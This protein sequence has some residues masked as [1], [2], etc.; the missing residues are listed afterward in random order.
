M[1]PLST[2]PNWKL[3]GNRPRTA[4]VHAYEASRTTVISSRWRDCF[5]LV[6]SSNDGLAA[7]SCRR[8]SVHPPRLLPGPALKGK[9][10]GL[11]AGLRMSKAEAEPW[12]HAVSGTVPSASGGIGLNPR[13]YHRRPQ[14]LQGLDM[15]T[16]SGSQM[17]CVLGSLGPV[18]GF[19]SVS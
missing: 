8:A 6:S 3:A 7:I 14:D 4:S 9:T 11:H 13:G 2:E 10:D 5:P 15:D 17:L 18:A 12:F 1:S 19:R 16:W